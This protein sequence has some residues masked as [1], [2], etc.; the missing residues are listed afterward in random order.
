MNCKAARC[1]LMI[2]AVILLVSAGCSP[3]KEAPLSAGE[4]IS[5]ELLDRPYPQY[6][7]HEFTATIHT[8]GTVEIYDNFIVITTEEGESILSPHGWYMDLTF[9]KQSKSR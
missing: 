6:K 3:R 4:L 7:N 5:V 8:D 9:R 2:T 1:L